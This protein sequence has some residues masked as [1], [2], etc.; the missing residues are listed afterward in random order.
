MTETRKRRTHT[1]GPWQVTQKGFVGY[2]VENTKQENVCIAATKETAQLI[3]AA[4]NMLE[5]LN[6]I[7]ILFDDIHLAI[8]DPDLVMQIKQVIEKA[9]GR[10]S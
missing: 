5:L 7:S 2:L 3:T 9:E 6:R 8:H 10:K 1:K 4:P